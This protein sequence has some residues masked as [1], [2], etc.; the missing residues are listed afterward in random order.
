MLAFI[1]SHVYEFY[2]A[3]CLNLNRAG[4]FGR[5]V[6]NFL[7]RSFVALASGT[8]YKMMS[9]T[10]EHYPEAQKACESRMSDVCLLF[11][12]RPHLKASMHSTTATDVIGGCYY[13]FCSCSSNFIGYNKLTDSH[14]ISTPFFLTLPQTVFCGCSPSC[15]TGSITKGYRSGKQFKNTCCHSV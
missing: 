10:S 7:A 4:W 15:R 13:P 11:H 12:C 1:I 8:F 5:L 6:Q 14:T 9:E 2:H 3:K